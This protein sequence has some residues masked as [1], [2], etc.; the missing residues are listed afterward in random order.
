MATAAAGSSSSSS[1]RAASTATGVRALAARGIQ[2]KPYLP[3]IHLMSFYRERF[4]H[5]EGE[6]PVCEDVAARSLALPFFPEMSE[7]QVARVADELRGVLVRRARRL[8]RLSRFS[9]P[10]HPDFQRLNASI[11]F[12]RRLW[13]QDIAQSRAHARMLAARGIISAE[14]RDACSR[15]STRS[16]PSCGGA[17]P[18]A[19]GDEDIHMAVERRLTEIVGPVGGRLHTARSRNDQVVTDLAMYTRA[20]AAEAQRAFERL[21]AVL[22][23]RAE[24]HLD[25]PMPGYTHL[26]RAQPVYL[27][28]HLL[29]YFWMLERDRER[30]AFAETPGRRAAARRGRARGRQLRHRPRAASPPSSASTASLRTRST[31]SPAA[32]SCSTTSLRPRPAPRTSRAS[33]PSWCCGR[34]PSSASASCRTPGARAPRSCRRRRTPTRRSCC[35]PR[36]RAS[37]G[38]WPPSTA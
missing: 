22:L 5:R 2:S 27:S 33:A 17:F 12:D 20:R 14:D 6:F 29:A 4:G 10:Q 7:G 28:H 16:R 11:A 34:A 13:P 25:W 36:R 9:E 19:A 23:A 30:F 18:F 38:T 8:P 37:S 31:P 1:C 3:A 21:M 35:G 26:Q 32:T 15:R 24:E